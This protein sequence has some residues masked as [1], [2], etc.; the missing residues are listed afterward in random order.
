M[1]REPYLTKSSYVRGITCQRLLWL[2]WHK[3]LPYEEPPPGSPAAVGT[4]IGNMAHK[5][6]PGGILVDQ[7]PWQHEE[8]VARTRALMA[9]PAVPAIFEAAYEHSGVR[10]RA[11]VMERLSDD[12]WGLREVKSAS[13][14]KARYIDDAA[15]QAFVLEHSDVNLRSIEIIHVN[16]KYVYPGGD[17][18]WPLYFQRSDVADQVRAAMPDIA[19]TIANHF[20][21]LHEPDE[22]PVEPSPHCPANCDY[23]DHCTARKPHD[24]ILNLPRLSQTKFDTLH[25]SGVDRITEIPDDFNL[26]DQQD[27]M[28]DVL[29]ASRPYVSDRLNADLAH[30]EGPAAYL[31]FEAMNPA[32]PIYPG[33]RPYQRIPFQWSLHRKDGTDT[34]S[35]AD[36]LAA[37][38][39]DPRE[40][41]T[42]SLVDALA[43]QAQEPI[44]VYS[45]YEKSV[46]REMAELFPIYAD[47]LEAI[48]DRLADLYVIVRNNVYLE[49]FAGSYSIKTVGKTLAPGFSYA[50]LDHVADGAEA[51][52]TFERLARND[53]PADEAAVLRNA[54]IEYCRHDTLAMVKAHQGLRDLAAGVPA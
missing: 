3:R 18:A 33:T 43:G 9:D 31:D 2:G 14:V 36:F 28:R 53:V 30:L 4:E 34:L 51:A 17:T 25:A 40:G 16:T 52:T 1:S 11:D 22:P 50:N 38:T 49:G 27:R 21:T 42:A 8:A 48:I 39:S 29:V 13:R 12:S 15:V 47:D 7:E 32:M 45:S 46:L 5:L 35:H 19:D 10:I 26:T 37:S 24:W 44:V 20:A 6:F 23:W 54:L 41:F